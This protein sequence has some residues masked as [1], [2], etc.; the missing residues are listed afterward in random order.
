M[1]KGRVE[2]KG[3][4]ADGARRKGDEVVGGVVEE[5]ADG[6][7]GKRRESNFEET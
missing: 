4:V 3:L 7:E 1:A 5:W 6:W 2:R